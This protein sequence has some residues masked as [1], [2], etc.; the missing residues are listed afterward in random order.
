MTNS[1][2]TSTP[3]PNKSWESTLQAEVAQ[4][5]DE[6]GENLSERIHARVDRVLYRCV[7]RSTN[8]NLSRAAERLG[9]SRPTL[10]NRIRQLNVSLYE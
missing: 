7:M 6:G 5:I 10:R 1:T 9:I 4:L 8:G 3:G 2:E